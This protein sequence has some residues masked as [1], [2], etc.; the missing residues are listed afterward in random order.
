MSNDVL[1][2][3]NSDPDIKVAFIFNQIITLID[4]LNILGTTIIQIRRTSKGRTS[5]VM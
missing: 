4:N 5:S 3:I 2:H 1:V